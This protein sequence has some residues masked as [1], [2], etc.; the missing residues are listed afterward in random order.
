MIKSFLQTQKKQKKQRLAC[1]TLPYTQEI[2]GQRKRFQLTLLIL[3]LVASFYTLHY[4]QQYQKT[5]KPI[6]V[7]VAV[8]NIKGPRTLALTDIAL[9]EIPRG[10]L[11]SSYFT[12]LKELEAKVLVSDIAS[13]AILTPYHFKD[14]VDPDS[15][16]ALF[17]EDFAFTIDEEWLMSR[18][19]SL[20][21]NDLVDI[22]V[23]NPKSKYGETMI[24]ASQIRVI[25]VKKFKSKKTLVLQ[26]T[27]EQAQPITFSRG[28]RLPMQ[29]LI[30][31]APKTT[32]L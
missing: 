19:P 30:H 18:L 28:L 7:V 17:S 15:I 22:I 16:S 4:F 14:S 10:Y 25:E 12:T 21:P 27:K 32:R 20:R 29:V 26:M 11:P 6:E 1:V 31:A 24:V 23:S 9:R 2:R 5:H 8:T 3:I 13:G